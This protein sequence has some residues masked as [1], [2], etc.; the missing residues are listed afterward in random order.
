MK[1]IAVEEYS[2]GSATSSASKGQPDLVIAEAD[3]APLPSAA[4]VFASAPREGTKTARVIGLLQ[5]D[6]GATLAELIAATD[7]LPHTTRAAL[8]GLRRRGFIVMLDRSSKERGSTY[9]IAREQNFAREA[10]PAGTAERPLGADPTKV[11]HSTKV[12]PIAFSAIDS[13]V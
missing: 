5:R 11:R 8:T 12:E 7:W 9:S 1:A 10:A 3:T 2:D 13:A 6:H 4:T